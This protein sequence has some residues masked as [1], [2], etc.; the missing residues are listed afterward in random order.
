MNSSVTTFHYQKGTYIVVEG[1]KSG[2][3]FFIVQDGEVLLSRAIS[4]RELSTETLK[5]GD[6]FEVES[7]LTGN[8]R[9]STA[10]AK[11]DVVIIAV[12]REMFDVLIQKR[13]TLVEKFILSFSNKMRNLDH[14][15]AK[16]SLKTM[17][18]SKS[19]ETVL[20]V[21]DY[22]ETKE[23]F[24]STAFIYH[25]LAAQNP[26]TSIEKKALEKYKIVSQQLLE[27]QKKYV[28]EAVSGVIKVPADT[29][30]VAEGLSGRTMF[31]IQEGR[32]KI[33]KIANNSELVLAVLK[34]GNLFGEMALLEDKPRSASAITVKDSELLVINQQ[35][36]PLLVRRN[37]KII[38]RITTVLADRIWFIYRQIVNASMRTTEERIYDGLLMFMER[39][40]SEEKFS[41]KYE[42]DISIGEFFTR[43]GVNPKQAEQTIT[44]LKNKQ[45]ITEVDNKI[46]V[47]NP[48][49]I[50]SRANMFRTAQLKDK[51]KG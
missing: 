41:K 45:L 50:T 29:M 47:L 31:F 15:L 7:G 16:V 4:V 10:I 21:A 51:K 32:V 19:L 36:F 44:D 11:T 18:E 17:E 25:N 20:E 6:F 34:K 46:I 33:C 9:L 43:I 8:K 42:L 40:V 26:G 27:D 37:P 3:T 48:K 24:Q 49:L 13:P 22:Y 23:K 5:S 35:T 39:Y 14:I 38:T 2:G 30:I 1:E 12:K 28:Q